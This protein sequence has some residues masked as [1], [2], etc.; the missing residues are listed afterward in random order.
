MVLYFE[1]RINAHLPTVFLAI[2]PTGKVEKVNYYNFFYTAKGDFVPLGWVHSTSI[3]G[4]LRPFR[5]L[6][7]VNSK[8]D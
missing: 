8:D 1:C 2:L 4:I 5:D 3:S 7:P 6:D